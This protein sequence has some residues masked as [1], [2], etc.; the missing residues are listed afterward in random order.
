[1][2]RMQMFELSLNDMVKLLT[3]RAPLDSMVIYPITRS[4]NK[5]LETGKI[6][7]LSRS[8]LCLE[9]STWPRWLR[10]WPPQVGTPFLIVLAWWRLA[11][12]SPIL[13]YGRASFLVISSYLHEH[14]KDGK[15]QSYDLFKMAYFDLALHF[16]FLY[17]VGVL[18]VHKRLTPSYSSR[19]TCH[20]L[21]WTCA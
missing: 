12:C 3:S 16:F 21:I 7:N 18:K 5:H 15:L 4:P 1:M 11:N 17:N 2:P 9:H 6:E 14:H 10:Y 19:H 13:H 20:R 8:Y